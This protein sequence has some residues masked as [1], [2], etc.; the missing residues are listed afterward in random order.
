MAEVS[1]EGAPMYSFCKGGNLRVA[2]DI[3]MLRSR[4]PMRVLLHFDLWRG[5]LIIGTAPA[6]APY[7]GPDPWRLMRHE[8]S[9]VSNV[10]ASCKIAWRC[11]SSRRQEKGCLRA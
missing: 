7:L 1:R 6:A 3:P 2:R 4:I 5:D 10:L 11:S 9:S 8:S